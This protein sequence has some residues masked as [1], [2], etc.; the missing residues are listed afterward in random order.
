MIPG[1]G[2]HLA[3]LKAGDKKDVEI[4]FPAEFGA[5]PDLAGKKATYAVE[6]QEIRE[7]VMPT[8]DEAFFKA[9]QADDLEGLKTNVRNNIK[10]Q[11]AG[12]KD[13]P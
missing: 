9:N 5:A 2:K 6:V 11:K 3:G 8:L 1:L 4:E 10:M 12:A 13:W 7:R